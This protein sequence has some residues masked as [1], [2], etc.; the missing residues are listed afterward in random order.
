MTENTGTRGA[1]KKTDPAL[2]DKVKAEIQA[3]DKG[4]E[5]GEWSARK[6]Q[7]AVSAYKKAG[8]GYE[9][10]KSKDNHLA[11]WT[12]EEWGTK[13]GQESGESGERYLPKAARDAL[14]DEE[15]ARTSA[16]KRS[17]GRAGKQFSSQPEDVARKT[18]KARKTA[19]KK[20]AAGNNKT[21]P[22]RSAKPAGSKPSAKATAPDGKSKAP[23]S[24]AKG[25]AAPKPRTAA[26]DRAGK[27]RSRTTTKPQQERAR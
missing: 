22:S 23:K 20:D 19:P 4:G 8:G 17:D 18:A 21:A 12:R 26:K 10:R 6:A 7:L 24:A 11:Q 5:P 25:K 27:A 13:S 14:S 2:W 9:G 15:Y 16:K 3:G 1:A